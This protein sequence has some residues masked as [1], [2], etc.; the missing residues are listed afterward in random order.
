VPRD[1][2]LRE[3]HF[4][5]FFYSFSY[6]DLTRSFVPEGQRAHAR[7]LRRRASTLHRLAVQ[8]GKLSAL[9]AADRAWP[10]RQ[11][12]EAQNHIFDSTDER[13]GL[14]IVPGANPFLVF[15]NDVSRATALGIIID[16]PGQFG[17]RH[18]I[19]V[20]RAA[21]EARGRRGR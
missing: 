7:R 6:L 15:P 4:F 10:R 1:L 14:R 21:L 3:S 20:G 16:P 5:Y 9:A 19:G 18:R 17:T 13:S 11:T 8:D 12:I 2:E